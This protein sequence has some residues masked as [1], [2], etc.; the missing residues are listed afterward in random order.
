MKA[1]IVTWITYNNYGTALQAFALQQF[2]ELHGIDSVIVSD[3]LVLQEFWASNQDKV[4]KIINNETNLVQGLHNNKKR[5]NLIKICKKEYSDIVERQYKRKINRQKNKYYRLFLNKFIDFKKAYLNILYGLSGF[6]MS[7]LNQSTDVFICGSDQI[8]SLLP[9]NFNSYYFLDFANKRKVSYAA[10]VGSNIERLHYDPLR[11]LLKDFSYISVR[12]SDTAIQLEKI[13]GRSVEWVVDPTLLHNGNFWRKV[14]AKKKIKRRSYLFCYFL[15]NKKWYFDYAYHMA[16]K[17][18]LKI[19][20]IPNK[21]EYLKTEYVCNFPVGP[22]EFVNLIDKSSYVLTDSYH[23]VLFSINLN[24]KFLYLKRF[25]DT[26]E[27]CQ[28]IRIYSL[29]NYLNLDN[30]IIEKKQFNLQDIKP[31]DYLR[32]NQDIEILREKSKDFLLRSLL[33]E[34]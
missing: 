34:Y 18:G 3:E 8:W 15:D 22:F 20:L 29:L 25:E 33:N 28:N 10:S 24:K 14:S 11:A 26:D 17:L 12:E 7:I 5:F 1:T 2:L 30:L 32:V 6:D 21:E 23:G 9:K 27:E 19:L 31:I 4:E 13:L 16:N